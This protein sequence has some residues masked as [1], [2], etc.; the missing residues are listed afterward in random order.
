[1]KICDSDS[2]ELC[3]FLLLC[4]YIVMSIMYLGIL[5]FVNVRLIP[6]DN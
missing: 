5:G 1:M 3:G 4:N 6:Y 2:C